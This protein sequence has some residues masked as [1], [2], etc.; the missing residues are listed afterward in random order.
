MNPTLIGSASAT[1]N[2][3]W[4]CQGPGVTVVAF[5]PS[6]APVPPPM[7]VVIPLSSATSACS[8]LIKCTCVSM[9]PAVTILPSAAMISVVAPIIMS[10]LSIISGLPALPIPII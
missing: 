10:T 2:M 5:V 9:P 3:R 6:E 8:G 4:I 1:S 7:C